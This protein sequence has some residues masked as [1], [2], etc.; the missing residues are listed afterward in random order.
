M[1][2]C[3]YQNLVNED[4]RTPVS[5]DNYYTICEGDEKLSKLIQIIKSKGKSKIIIFMSTCAAVEY[6]SLV[7]KRQ[8]FIF[9]I[10]CSA[11]YNM[12]KPCL[13]LVY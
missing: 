12:S 9:K 1:Y 6:F 2:H 11:A 4:S 10:S 3:A 7:L 13:C 8:V 5:L